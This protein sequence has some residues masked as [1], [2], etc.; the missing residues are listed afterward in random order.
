MMKER[1]FLLPAFC[2]AAE[3]LRETRCAFVHTR[4]AVHMHAISC[5]L[6]IPKCVVLILIYRGK[7]IVVQ[8]QNAKMSATKV[9]LLS[10]SMAGLLMLME[11]EDLLL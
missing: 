5:T 10:A 6:Y 8:L 3:A 1:V 11:E 7:N 4:T 9:V 2:M